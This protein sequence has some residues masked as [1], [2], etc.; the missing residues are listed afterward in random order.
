MIYIDIYT[1]RYIHIDIYTHTP[2]YAHISHFEIVGVSCFS[3][4]I[5]GRVLPSDSAHP[6]SL[7]SVAP[8]EDWVTGT[9]SDSMMMKK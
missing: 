5:S 2:K 3:K 6:W 4:F 9:M 8:L 1:H 7:Y